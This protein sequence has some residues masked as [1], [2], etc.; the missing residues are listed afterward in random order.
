[1]GRGVPSVNICTALTPT[2]TLSPF[3]PPQLVQ[4][5][6]TLPPPPSL[7]GRKGGGEGQGLSHLSRKG[8]EKGMGWGGGGDT[9]ISQTPRSALGTKADFRSHPPHSPRGEVFKSPFSRPLQEK[10]HHE[11]ES[12]VARRIAGGGGEAVPGRG[13]LD[14]PGAG[15]RRP[16]NRESRFFNEVRNKMYLN[17]R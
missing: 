10:P 6:Q 14:R 7:F 8:W 15:G 11:E 2:T 5:R 13:D 12:F 9:Q 16:K 17:Y 1:M 4:K 3:P